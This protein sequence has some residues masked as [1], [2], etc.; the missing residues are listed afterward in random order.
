MAD[1]SWYINFGSFDY[2]I[3]VLDEWGNNPKQIALLFGYAI[4]HW[5]INRKM[6]VFGIILRYIPEYNGNIYTFLKKL[7]KKTCICDSKV[8]NA[9]DACIAITSTPE[10]DKTFTWFCQGQTWHL[11]GIVTKRGVNMMPSYYDVNLLSS[12]ELEKLP[13]ISKKTAKKIKNYETSRLT[14]VKRLIVSFTELIT[15]I[16][17]RRKEMNS[18]AKLVFVNDI[19]IATIFN[20]CTSD[21]LYYDWDLKVAVQ[22]STYLLSNYNDLKTS[23]ELSFKYRILATFRNLTNESD[24]DN[25]LKNAR[26]AYLAFSN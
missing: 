4:R 19:G 7:V 1:N 21:I 18:I 15:C 25:L 3:Q 14:R 12:N 5:L 24:N 6:N 13:G 10:G 16:D 9:K 26:V 17:V 20:E 22:R 23:E 8:F 2:N 11:L